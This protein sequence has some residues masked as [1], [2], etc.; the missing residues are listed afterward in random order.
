MVR[1]LFGAGPSAARLGS[2]QH[3]WAGELRHW[4]DGTERRTLWEF[5]KA[6]LVDSHL[7]E[8][9]D[10]IHGSFQNLRFDSILLGNH[11]FPMSFVAGKSYH[12]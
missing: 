4:E 1:E 9:G 2:R 6:N 12:L 11:P 7:G 3:L 5:R 10:G 8:D